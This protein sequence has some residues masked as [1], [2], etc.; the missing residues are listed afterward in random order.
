MIAR[1]WSGRARHHDAPRY[2]AHARTTVMGHLGKIRGYRGALV[3]TQERA[4]DTAVTVLTFWDS[5]DAVSA[6]AGPDADVAVVEPEAEAA[7]I[8]YDRRVRHFEVAASQ[9]VWPGLLQP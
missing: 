1:S 2:V 7:L 8:D 5:M 6:F 9:A 3:L 4:T